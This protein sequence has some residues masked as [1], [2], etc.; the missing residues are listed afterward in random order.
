M[1]AR[2]EHSSPPPAN[3]NSTWGPEKVPS[4]TRHWGSG[5]RRIRWVTNLDRAQ[6]ASGEDW[7][8]VVRPRE[9]G[10]YEALFRIGG[11]VEAYPS[12]DGPVRTS[13][14]CKAWVRLRAEA[15]ADRCGWIAYFGKPSPKA[16]RPQSYVGRYR[17]E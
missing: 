9:K 1:K 12:S 5:L 17:S 8:A 2:P 3:G 4:A 16:R 10:G 6:V 11:L 13:E 14:Q 7:G 15:A